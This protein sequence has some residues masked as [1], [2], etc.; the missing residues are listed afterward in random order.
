MKAKD[1]LKFF[2]IEGRLVVTI[3]TDDSVQAAMQKLVKDHLGALPVC[4]IKGK[5][6]RGI[7]SERDMVENMFTEYN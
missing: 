5:L 7:V 3:G 1:F 4:G 2:R 6:L